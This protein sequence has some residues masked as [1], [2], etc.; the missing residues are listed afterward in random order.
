[1]ETEMWGVVDGSLPDK[2]IVSH[3]ILISS[4]EGRRSS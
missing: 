4:E 2:S 1:M 3:G